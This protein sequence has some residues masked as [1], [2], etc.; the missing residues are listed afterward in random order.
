MAPEF[1]IGSVARRGAFNTDNLYVV[2]V[3]QEDA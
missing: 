1:S 2:R 3:A